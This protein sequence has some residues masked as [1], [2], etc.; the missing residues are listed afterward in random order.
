MA[1]QEPIFPMMPMEEF[2]AAV[3]AHEEWLAGYGIMDPPAIEVARP[4]RLEERP[5]RFFFP[6]HC[7]KIVANSL[8]GAGAH[9]EVEYA[10]SLCLRRDGAFER[11][12]EALASM[13]LP[14]WAKDE[15]PAVVAT[16]APKDCVRRLVDAVLSSPDVEKWD[17]TVYT[18]RSYT[19]E[20]WQASP[21][22]HED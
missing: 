12:T 15:R 4:A 3:R 7:A 8:N 9:T 6:E 20:E 2:E 14:V 13:D 18:P 19:D 11:G 10:I 22:A 5:W 21:S 17:R 16:V 1:D